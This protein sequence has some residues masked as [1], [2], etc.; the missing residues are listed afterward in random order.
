M[1]KFIPILYLVI[2]L[3]PADHG[4]AQRLLLLN[5]FKVNKL[6]TIPAFSDSSSADDYC[7][8]KIV[9][10]TLGK[11]QRT[12]GIFVSN[13]DDANVLVKE[14]VK[15]IDRE[16]EQA[17]WFFDSYKVI[18]KYAAP[19]RCDMLFTYLLQQH[20]DLKRSTF[21]MGSYAVR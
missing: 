15:D 7:V 19:V 8:C 21:L 17:L 11:E 2:F 13:P 12:D 5:K 16:L 6:V 20:Q 3:H 14:L 4:F 18:G 1:R 10:F 9:K